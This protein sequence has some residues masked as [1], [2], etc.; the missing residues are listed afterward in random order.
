MPEVHVLFKG[1]YLP[2]PPVR[3]VATTA[4]VLGEGYTWVVDP[5]T[6]PAAALTAALSALGLEPDD[7]DTVF[8]THGH[9]DHI[10]NTGLFTLARVLDAWGWW[11]GDTW[12]EFDGVLPPGLSLLP[13]PGHSSDM[14]TLL[15][16][17]PAACVAICGD[18]F[19]DGHSLSAEDPFAEDF[20]LLL[21]SR[22]QVLS[23]ADSV[24]PGHGGLFRI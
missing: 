11:E 15:V 5:G 6:A 16:D 2:G 20:T 13:T 17:T 7:V 21:E 3:A 10:R 1:Y 18:V 4:L 22:R 12:R 9:M 8:L 23:R 14:L 19:Y 24:I